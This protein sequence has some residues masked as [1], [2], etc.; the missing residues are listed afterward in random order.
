MIICHCE[1]VT[2]RR[3]AKAVRA[4]SSSVRAVCAQTGAGKSC[5][6]CV[7][8]VKKLIEKHLAPTD[9]GERSHEAA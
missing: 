8:S 6:G 1:R 9:Q 7:T 4:G 2:D 5:G 3:V